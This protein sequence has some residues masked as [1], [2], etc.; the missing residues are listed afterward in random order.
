MPARTY[1]GFAPRGSVTVSGRTVEFTRGEPVEF[2]DD[3]AKSLDG[4][5]ATPKPAKA[6][7]SPAPADKKE[8]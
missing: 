1:T 2:S 8:S 3:E 6:D 5:W 4:D 7:K